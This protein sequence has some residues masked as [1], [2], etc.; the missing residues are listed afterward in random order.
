MNTDDEKLD[1]EDERLL[2]ALEAVLSEADELE[3][4]ERKEAERKKIE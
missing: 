1:R 4:E 3:E 2:I